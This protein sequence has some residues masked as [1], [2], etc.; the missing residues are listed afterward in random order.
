MSTSREVDNETMPGENSRFAE[1][2]EN[3]L[4]QKQD[5]TIPN[6][7]KKATK[8]GIRVFRDKWLC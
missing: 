8:L 5:I 7:M 6:D 4:L 1:V 2:V 3:D